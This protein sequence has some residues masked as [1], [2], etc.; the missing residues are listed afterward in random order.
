[1]PRE[2]NQE[3][4]AKAREYWQYCWYSWEKTVQYSKA[5]FDTELAGGSRSP[6]YLRS[7]KYAI[8]P[9]AKSK[10]GT[11]WPQGLPGEVLRKGIDDSAPSALWESDFRGYK[12]MG[13]SNIEGKRVLE[14]GCGCGLESFQLAKQGAILT[15][16][17]IVPSNAEVTRRVLDIFPKCNA[18]LLDDYKD[19]ERLGEF[20][21]V[22]S[23]GV[24]HHIPPEFAQ[25]AV[26]QLKQCLGTDGFFMVLVYTKRYYH[27]P[28]FDQEGPYTCGYD[29]EGLRR[30]FGSD[31]VVSNYRIFN[32]NTYMTA[33]LERGN[34]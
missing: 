32:H 21:I 30:L 2:M 7:T 19:I 34:K 28:S 15:A 4:F 3:Y 13:M 24:L 14:F 25:A 10:D 12:S 6:T 1:M 26:N 5:E 18:V 17:D 20:D 11:A 33:K 31:M 9:G 22:F 8:S 27:T 29:V 16:C 23:S